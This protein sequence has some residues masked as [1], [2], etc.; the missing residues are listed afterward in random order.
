MP[1]AGASQV[2]RCEK[3]R[4]GSDSDP[5]PQ[6]LRDDTDLRPGL[7][8]L[9]VLHKYINCTCPVRIRSRAFYAAANLRVR[10]PNCLRLGPRPYVPRN[11]LCLL[12]NVST[13]S[14]DNRVGNTSIQKGK[15]IDSAGL[16]SNGFLWLHV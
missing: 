16:V 7:R 2:T 8:E 10:L 11:G 4:H 9:R 6:A 12:A 13:G 1:S 15:D 14:Y 5:Q 3:P